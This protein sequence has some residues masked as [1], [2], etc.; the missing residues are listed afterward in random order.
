MTRLT[1]PWP[2]PLPGSRDRRDQFRA[3]EDGCKTI[4]VVDGLAVVTL[5]SGV[6]TVSGDWALDDDRAQEPAAQARQQARK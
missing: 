5:D 6:V 2:V 1:L 3:G 4:R